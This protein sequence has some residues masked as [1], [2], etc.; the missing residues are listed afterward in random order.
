M[1][2]SHDVTMKKDGGPC[3]IIDYTNLNNAVPRQTNIIY[4]CI[5]V[6]AAQKE[7]NFG[8]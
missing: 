3:R 7:N 4:V 6:F 8:R 2:K 1:V 5:C